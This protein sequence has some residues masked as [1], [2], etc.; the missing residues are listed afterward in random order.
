MKWNKTKVEG[1]IHFRQVGKFMSR[2]DSYGSSGHRKPGHNREPLMRA[3][4]ELTS[5]G[6]REMKSRWNCGSITC[7]ICLTC[8][9]SQ[10]SINS[11]SASSFSGPVQL[12]NVQRTFKK[13]KFN[14]GWWYHEKQ[15]MT[16]PNIK[17]HVCWL[18]VM[19]DQSLL[20]V[21]F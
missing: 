12:W 17:N 7:I 15:D 2:K 6:S 16:D 8:V 13:K 4:E 11:S 18:S 21:L 5:L 20:H 3:G 14:V 19:Y 1:T 10:L 9:G